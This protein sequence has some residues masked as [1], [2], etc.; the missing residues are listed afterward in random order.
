MGQEP[1]ATPE[2]ELLRA[3][4]VICAHGETANEQKAQEEVEWE[5]DHEEMDKNPHMQ[6]IHYA[7]MTSYIM[8]VAVPT[9]KTLK[10]MP[11]GTA[12]MSWSIHTMP[13]N[14]LIS[15]GSAETVK[16]GKDFAEI[17]YRALYG[18]VWRGDA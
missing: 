15:G 16:Q 11:P 10:G 14:E 6:E 7:E 9:L 12:R 5:L 4:K 13:Q 18:T 8:Y 1:N 17:G 3:I 2:Q